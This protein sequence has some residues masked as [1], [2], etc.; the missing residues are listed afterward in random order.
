MSEEVEESRGEGG[1]GEKSNARRDAGEGLT[2]G[3][4][5]VRRPGGWRWQRRRW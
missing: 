4:R 1:R 5:K 2:D 3:W